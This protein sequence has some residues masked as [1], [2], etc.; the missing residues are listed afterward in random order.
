MPRP[1]GDFYGTVQM[2]LPE[3]APIRRA[4]VLLDLFPTTT[5]RMRSKQTRYPAMMPRGS[6]AL[7]LLGNLESAVLH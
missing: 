4:N 3:L 2:L 5:A 1:Q 6:W 7:L